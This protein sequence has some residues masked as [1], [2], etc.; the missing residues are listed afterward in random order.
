MFRFLSS[1]LPERKPQKKVEEAHPG[2]QT[3]VELFELHRYG[4]LNE[5]EPSEEK[6][7]SWMPDAQ[8]ATLEEKDLPAAPAPSM[9]ASIFRRPPQAAPEPDPEIVENEK[10]VRFKRIPLSDFIANDPMMKD[11]NPYLKMQPVAKRPDEYT[12]F[13]TLARKHDFDVEEP[14]IDKVLKGWEKG[15]ADY[16]EGARIFVSYE[17]QFPGFR[18]LI[19]A[20]GNPS[21][22]SKSL[23]IIAVNN[24]GALI[25][26]MLKPVNH[27]VTPLKSV[28]EALEVIY[29]GHPD[30][31]ITY[32]RGDIELNRHTNA[33]RA[34]AQEGLDFLKPG[35]F[36]MMIGRTP[37]HRRVFDGKMRHQI[38]LLYTSPSPR[39]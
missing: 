3:L 14:E 8:E 26:K 17:D 28:A 35:Q 4:G 27:E 12:L 22:R 32:G 6:G 33:A 1:L 10:G 18:R 23:S 36:T 24:D 25:N 30:W 16:I 19:I 9:V 5:I 15:Y 2:G 11:L 31:Q 7:A 39:D 21:Q 37:A 20:G 38:C 13:R 29:K 34:M